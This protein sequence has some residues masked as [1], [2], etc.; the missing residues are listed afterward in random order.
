[1]KTN[2]YL[3][4]LAA[5]L[6]FPAL[7]GCDKD[8]GALPAHLEFAEDNIESRSEDSQIYE[9][10]LD[11]NPVPNGT[12]EID[13]DSL[14]V[15][16][17]GEPTSNPNV[18]LIKIWGFS[19][20][21][22]YLAWA[23]AHGLPAARN[24]EIEEHLSSY[25][26]ASGADTIYEQ[27]GEVPQWYT[28]YETAYLKQMGL[29]RPDEVEMRTI[30]WLRKNCGDSGGA[31]MLRTLPVMWPGWNK[32]VSRYDNLVVLGNVMMYDRTFYRKRFYNY[33]DWGWKEVCFRGPLA[34][35]ND[36]MSSGFNF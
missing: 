16:V 17:T 1:M 22:G 19:S 12:F 32:K 2:V 21:E 26:E 36:R 29:F 33:W 34:E 24:L 11:R 9:F 31:P 7:F 25:A 14:Y 20:R 15:A 18:G 30:C 23:D 13:D 4:A 3:Y 27:T 35:F 8:K 6:C 28:D 5:A 10:Y